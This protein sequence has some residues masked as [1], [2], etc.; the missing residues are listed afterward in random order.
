LAGGSGCG[1]HNI[2]IKKDGA[3]T[4]CVCAQ[5]AP[6]ALQPP[7][8]VIVHA[9]ADARARW[10][11]VFSVSSVVTAAAGPARQRRP[12]RHGRTAVG[13]GG[14]AVSSRVA[15]APVESHVVVVRLV[16]HS[17]VS[18]ARPFT[19]VY[20]TTC[21]R[22]RVRFRTFRLCVLMPMPVRR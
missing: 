2:T 1:A 20:R 17:P 9:A 7:P 8:P 14:G 4:K 21:P 18:F 13:G 11:S 22:N 16:G 19:R 5:G 6:P 10:P 15:G 3:T 12:P